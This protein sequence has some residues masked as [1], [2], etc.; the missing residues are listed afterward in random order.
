MCDFPPW[1]D[2][3]GDQVCDLSHVGT[4]VCIRIKCTD[5]R[6]VEPDLF[7]TKVPCRCVCV[8]VCVCVC[9]C[10]RV[11]VCVRVCACAYVCVRVSIYLSMHVCT[12]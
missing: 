1:G 12:V 9:V 8:H 7:T 4:L 11:C 2:S 10:A 6:S 5:C 3:S